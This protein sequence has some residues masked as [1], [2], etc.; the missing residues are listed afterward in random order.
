MSAAV[1]TGLALLL[2]FTNIA[3]GIA[4]VYAG[5]RANRKANPQGRYGMLRP[6]SGPVTD[7]PEHRHVWG[8]WVGEEAPVAGTD[9]PR[10]VG[11]QKR[12]CQ[13]PSCEWTDRV[14][15]RARS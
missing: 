11:I 4:G 12:Q 2:I 14:V 8:P 10:R 6:L 7:E 9:P 5:A 13:D 15:N 3:A 1:S